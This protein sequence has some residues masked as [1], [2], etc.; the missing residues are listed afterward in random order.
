MNSFSK[1]HTEH[2]YY[3]FPWDVLALSFSKSHKFEH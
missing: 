2:L 1:D 3:V